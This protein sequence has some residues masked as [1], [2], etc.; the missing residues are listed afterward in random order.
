M[1]KENDRLNEILKQEK[2]DVDVC[3]DGISGR[4]LAISG[5]YDI[6]VLDVILPKIRG[7]DIAREIIK[8]KYGLGLAIAKSI[9]ILIVNL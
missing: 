4:D 5:I 6:I 8:R 1:K 2:Y 3:Y 9:V 7:F